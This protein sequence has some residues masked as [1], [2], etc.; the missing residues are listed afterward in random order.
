MDGPAALPTQPERR[1]EQASKTSVAEKKPA[2]APAKGVTTAAA[3]SPSKPSTTAARKT[4]APPPKADAQAS[5]SAPKQAKPSS[6]TSAKAGNRDP[7]VELLNAIMK[8]LGDGKAATTAAAPTRSPQTIAELVKSCRTKDAI[9]ELM[10]QRRICEGSWGKAQACPKEQ[11]PKA[12]K[13]ASPA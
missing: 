3:P 4:P 5:A 11:A 7:D 10:C 13:T 6:G 8:H 9:E 12:A 1:A 2:T